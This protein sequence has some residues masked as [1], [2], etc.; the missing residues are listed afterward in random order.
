MRAGRVPGNV[1][2]LWI[3]E[4][5]AVNPNE[6]DAIAEGYPDQVKRLTA[7]RKQVLDRYSDLYL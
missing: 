1:I 7:V 3:D 4:E 6:F 2:E 5:L